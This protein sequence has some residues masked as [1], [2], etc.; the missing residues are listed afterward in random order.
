MEYTFNI[1]GSYDQQQVLNQVLDVMG[2]RLWNEYTDDETSDGWS[3]T[4][5]SG[6][7]LGFKQTLTQEQETTLNDLMNGLTIDPNYSDNYKFKLTNSFDDPSTIDY[8]IYGLHK[9]L[10]ILFGELRV[11]DYY[12]N[13]DPQTYTYSDLVVKELRDYT[14]D[15][16]G[17]VQYR[18]QTSTWYLNN[19]T[20][21]KTTTSTKYYSLPQAIQ[22][23][24]DRRGNAIAQTK[25][26]V[27]SQIGQ[28][29]SFDLLTGVKNDIQLYVDG[30]TDPLR[31]SIT[32]STKPYLNTTIKDGIIENLR[33]S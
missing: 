16:N 29:Y 28:L 2:L 22:E 3:Y 17:L 6:L 32:N 18:L 27:L 9:N 19:G 15:V 30:Y 13:Y 21:G 25:A 7:V 12:R 26:Y 1:E 8:D 24:L 5:E 10:T 11:T 20:T 4:S 31:L 14:R 23:G 33:L